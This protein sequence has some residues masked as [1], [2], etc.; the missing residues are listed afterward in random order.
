MSRSRE[1]GHESI[2]TQDECVASNQMYQMYVVLIFLNSFLIKLCVIIIIVAYRRDGFW[3]SYLRSNSDGRDLKQ[4]TNS[5]DWDLV[6]NDLRK[7]GS[8]QNLVRLALNSKFD[9]SILRRGGG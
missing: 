8:S 5:I 9:A 7:I 6:T 1:R 2:I 4:F 3:L